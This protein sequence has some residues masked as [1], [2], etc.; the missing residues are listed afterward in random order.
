M[1][2]KKLDGS[3]YEIPQSRGMPPPV[4]AFFLVGLVV[5]L[6]MGAISALESGHFHIWP[7]DSAPSIPLGH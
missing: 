4:R 6:F 7:V 2:D 5:I 3:Q 1:S